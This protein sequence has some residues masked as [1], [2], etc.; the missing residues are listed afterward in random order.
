MEIIFKQ[1]AE[2]SEISNL[3]KRSIKLFVSAL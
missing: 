1:N 2:I 3:K